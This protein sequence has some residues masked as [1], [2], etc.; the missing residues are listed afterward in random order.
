MP[1]Q[2]RLD[3]PPALHHIIV[4][5]IT[6]SAIFK[7]TQDRSLILARLGQNIVEAQSSVHALVLVGNH[8][9]VRSGRQGISAIMR[10]LLTWYAQYYNRRH[11]RRG[12][13]FEP[14]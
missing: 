12:D 2:T 8:P 13:L 11:R 7:D 14:L 3:T 6:L 1:R 10:K 4:R 5:G 9:L